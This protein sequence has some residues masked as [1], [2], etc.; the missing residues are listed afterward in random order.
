MARAVSAR[1][2]GD[3]YQ[4]RAFWLKACRLFQSHT[5]VVRIG[6]EI[7]DMPHFDDIAVFYDNGAPNGHGATLDSDYYQIKWHVDQSG[8][9]TCE[10]LADPAF[11]GSR[12][13]SLLQRLKESFEISSG[14]GESARFNFVTTWTIQAKD[15]LGKLVS[16]VNGQIR[17]DTLFGDSAPSRIRHI[18]SKWADHLE[19][20]ECTL[21]R[22]LSNFRLCANAANLERLTRELS[23]RLA[24]A[25][26]SP[27]E[28]GRLSNKYDSL[29][30]ALHHGGQ[31][32]FSRDEI[33]NICEAE[34]L[35]SE[36]NPESDLPVV[37]IR[38][39][40]RFA[41][42]L[43]DETESLL[44]LVDLF[45]GRRLRSEGLWNGPVGHE[46]RRFINE[47]VIPL[48]DC[49]IHLAAHS[50]VAFAAGYELD[51]KAG[52]RVSPIQNTASGRKVW[53][54]DATGLSTDQGGWRL[55][56]SEVNPDGREVGL[57]LSVTHSTKEDAIVFAERQLAQ[58]GRLLV[59]EIAPEIGFAS[60]RNGP[61]AMKLAEN[62][63]RIVRDWEGF[64][65]R[66][67]PLHIFTAAPNG[68][69]FFLGRLARSLGPIQLYEHDFDT[70]APGAYSASLRL[71]QQ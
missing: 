52:I 40:L 67:G 66:E 44:D 18:R 39:F 55:F 50:S 10:S 23:E 13:S 59:L 19:V 36:P 6:Y 56:E 12:R 33:R 42:H 31:T 24:V 41:E 20:D 71:P 11:I 17:L 3:A 69:V 5:K 68:L 49:S 34:G 58:L 16:G 37:G 70:N 22:I 29:I 48:G 8:S 46:I 15:P 63:I 2:Q 64:R 9:I 45:D 54:P 1:Q 47:S 21:R 25:G 7:N 43:E 53:P 57:A 32:T 30:S 61:H 65:I 27:I 26:L 60:V 51:P 14:R 28:F 38:S 4:A 35:L 62:V